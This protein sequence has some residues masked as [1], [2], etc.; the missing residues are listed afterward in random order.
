MDQP[1]AGAQ[2]EIR[3]VGRIFH[4]AVYRYAG[5][6]LYVEDGAAVSCPVGALRQFDG[7]G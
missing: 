4:E 3:T 5:A 6:R 2:G 7:G 1:L